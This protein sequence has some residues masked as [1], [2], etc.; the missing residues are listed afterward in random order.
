MIWVKPP[1]WSYLVVCKG[2]GAPLKVGSTQ[3]PHTRLSA[4]Q[5]NSPY[6]CDFRGPILTGGRDTERWLKATLQPWHSHAEWFRISPIDLARALADLPP[7]IRRYALY[8]PDQTWI[9]AVCVPLVQRCLREDVV[10]AKDR[11]AIEKLLSRRSSWL[12]CLHGLHYTHCEIVSWTKGCLPWEAM[13]G[14]VPEEYPGSPSDFYNSLFEERKA[15]LKA[16]L[17]VAEAA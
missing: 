14:L 8:K 15:R 10:V 3:N 1:I 13:L 16:A 11:C 2:Q 5:S 9:K 17:P 7:L 6:P 12:G 4:I